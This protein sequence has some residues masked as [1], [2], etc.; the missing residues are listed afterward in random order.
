VQ[1][2]I[3]HVETTENHSSDNDRNEAVIINDNNLILQ[4]CYNI[5]D[6]DTYEVNYFK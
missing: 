3:L 5:E 6:D 4:D 2:D 1:G